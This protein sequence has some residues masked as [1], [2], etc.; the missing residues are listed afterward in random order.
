MNNRNSIALEAYLKACKRFTNEN[1]NFINLCKEQGKSTIVLSQDG[2]AVIALREAIAWAM[3]LYDKVDKN[4]ITSE[5][6]AFMSGIKYID[7]VWKH[8]DIN[9]GLYS[10]MCPGMKI[11]VGVDEE[12]GK[13]EIK[14]VNIEPTLVWGELEDFPVKSQNKKQRR[15]FFTEVK[16]YSVI[17]SLEKIDCILKKYLQI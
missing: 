6:K 5:D 7:N 2:G 12:Y 17:E 16:K 1:E 15:N 13:P 14:D 10:I 4:I 3:S 11:S 9:F 8:E